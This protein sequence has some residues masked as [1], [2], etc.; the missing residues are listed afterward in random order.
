MISTVLKVLGVPKKIAGSRRS[1]EKHT[2]VREVLKI[3]LITVPFR[4]QIRTRR[5]QIRNIGKII[6]L[7][8]AVNIIK[9]RV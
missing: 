6:F 4:R 2:A 3:L 5:Q 7:E 9:R 8:Q 1:A